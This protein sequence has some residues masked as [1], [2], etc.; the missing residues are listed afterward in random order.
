MMRQLAR[1]TRGTRF[2]FI[3]VWVRL[4]ETFI[5]LWRRQRNFCKPHLRVHIKCCAKFL[6][7]SCQVRRSVRGT[8]HR[9]GPSTEI[10][11][12]YF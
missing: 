3:E 9:S 12:A 4:V 8:S 2:N 6:P 5:Y 7:G 1:A 10:K 11:Q